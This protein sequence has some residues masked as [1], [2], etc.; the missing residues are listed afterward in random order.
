[1]SPLTIAAM[2]PAALKEAAE[3]THRENRRA[4]VLAA[5]GICLSIRSMGSEHLA[6]VGESAMDAVADAVIAAVDEG[7]T[8][9]QATAAVIA[10]I[11]GGN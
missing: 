8:L 4:D 9:D 10:V 1:M 5:I 2:L 6:R 7:K 11:Y 3:E